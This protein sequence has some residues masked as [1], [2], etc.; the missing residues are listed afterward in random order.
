MSSAPASYK[1]R[2]QHQC[3]A[4]AFA[5]VAERG[6]FSLAAERLRLSQPAVSPQVRQLE[7]WFDTARAWPLQGH[8]STIGSKPP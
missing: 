3:E 2:A 5:L 8:T 1:G 4:C 6:S 7:K